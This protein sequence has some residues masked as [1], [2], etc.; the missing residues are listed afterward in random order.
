[1]Q[2]VFRWHEEDEEE[3]AAS[4]DIDEHGRE[5]TMRGIDVESSDDED[6]SWTRMIWRK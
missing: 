1:M 4:S 6:L 5:E 3:R 2:T